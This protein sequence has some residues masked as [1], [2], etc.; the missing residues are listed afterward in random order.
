M[1][2]TSI[3]DLCLYDGYNSQR[4]RFDISASAGLTDDRRNKGQYSVL[5]DKDKSGNYESRIDYA[6]NL[7]YAGKKMTL[8]N[9]EKVRLLGVNNNAGRLVSLP[10]IR[11]RSCARQRH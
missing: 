5:F 10:S 8:S 6:L 4:P 9:N 7:T 1:S 3:V 11:C 2:G